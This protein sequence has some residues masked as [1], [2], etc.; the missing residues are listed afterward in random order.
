M[1]MS[2]SIG[3]SIIAI[4]CIPFAL[5][6]FWLAFQLTNRLI[7][8]LSCEKCQERMPAPPLIIAAACFCLFLLGLL[9][10]LPA[11]SLLTEGFVWTD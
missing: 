1:S 8:K 3:M 10:L 6:I 5:A 2:D 11:Y 9:F 7:H 4:L